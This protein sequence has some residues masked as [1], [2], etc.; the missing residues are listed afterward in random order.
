MTWGER[1]LAAV[2]VV[3]AAA[4]LLAAWFTWRTY[5]AANQERQAS[6]L[7]P[8]ITEVRE[9]A[10]LIE[11]F[12]AA[13]SLDD[14]RELLSHQARLGTALDIFPE[15]MFPQTRLLGR[16]PKAD[17]AKKGGQID[18]ARRELGRAVQKISPASFGQLSGSAD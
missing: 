9:I 12:E 11:K 4:L 3:Q 16:L 10:G 7:Q 8:L 5:R 15:T 13:G 18:A 6:R 17:L 14:L 1:V 2:G